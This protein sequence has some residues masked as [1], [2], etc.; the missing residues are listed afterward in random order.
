MSAES[1]KKAVQYSLSSTARH[2]LKTLE[3]EI[4]SC[5]STAKQQGW[6]YNE[7]VA[8]MLEIIAVL[9]LREGRRSSPGRN[10]QSK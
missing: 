6:N 8:N 4:E 9:H 1:R 7:F 10:E 5:K 3:R 2:H